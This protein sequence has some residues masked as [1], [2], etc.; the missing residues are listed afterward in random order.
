MNLK[1]R[2]KTKYNSKFMTIFIYALILGSC[3]NTFGQ[4]LEKMDKKELRIAYQSLNTSKNIMKD[5]LLIE[6]NALKL[7]SENKTSEINSLKQTL[8]LK[9]NKIQEVDNKISELQKII[10]QQEENIKILSIK[11][12]QLNHFSR[13][14]EEFKKSCNLTYSENKQLFQSKKYILFENKDQNVC[15]IYLDDKLVYINFKEDKE[16]ENGKL[17]TVYSNDNLTISISNQELIG[18][19]EII[20]IYNAVITVKDKNGQT[21]SIKVYSEGGC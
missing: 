12:L 14:P 11:P 10:A 7:L 21:T 8:T 19:T 9:Q 3:P 4:E 17:S 20:Q 18:D 5:S 1:N 13:I 16:D 2:L 6:L 15:I